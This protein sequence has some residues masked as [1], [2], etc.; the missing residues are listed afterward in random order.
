MKQK[1]SN[2]VW[3]VPWFRGYQIL[4]E[5]YNEAEDIEYCM[6][7]TIKQWISNIVWKVKWTRGY[8]ILYEKINEAEDIKYCLK[9]TLKQRIS[10]IVWKVQWYRKLQQS[11][12]RTH[13]IANG[14]ETRVQ[15]QVKSYQRL[16]KWYLMLPCLTLSIVR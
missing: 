14:W 3:K 1:I 10:N 2:I 15:S 11:G 4:Y 12:C 6:K 5:K 16:K 9:S 7:C 8:Q 13:H